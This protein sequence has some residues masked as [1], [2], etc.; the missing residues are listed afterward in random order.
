MSNTSTHIKYLIILLIVLVLYI[1]RGIQ[2]KTDKIN[3]ETE[4]CEEVELLERQVDHLQ[5]ENDIFTSMLSEIENEPGG[6]EILKKLW[7]EK[8]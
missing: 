4:L 6:H 3:S 5:K 2:Y 1:A 7:N 8:K